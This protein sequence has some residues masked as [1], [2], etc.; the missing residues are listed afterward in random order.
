MGTGDRVS[1]LL[2]EDDAD[3]AAMLTELL[4]EEGYAVDAV[5]DGQ[6]GLHHALTA[7]PDLMVVDRRLPAIDG[8]DLLVRLRSRGVTA[9]ALMLTALAGPT[10]RVEG[11]DAGADDYL[12]KPF[13]VDELLAR[14]RAL[15]RRHTDVADTLRLAGGRLFDLEGRRVVDETGHDVQLSGREA[16]LLRVLAGR[17]RRV[18][19]RDELLGL[20]FTEADSPGAVDTYVYYL[21]RKIGRDVIATVHGLGYRLGG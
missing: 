14:L 8:V 4:A 20:V 7:T 3:L 10:D 9:P 15:R 2:V 12:G 19:S 16:A 21:R 18:F 1:V 13:D 6:A 11:L 17:P 5:R